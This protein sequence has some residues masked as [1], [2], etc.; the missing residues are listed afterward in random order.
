M[1]VQSSKTLL[2]GYKSTMS[3][4]ENYLQR[5]GEHGQSFSAALTFSSLHWLLA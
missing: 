2:M 1:A 5:R 3:V 4:R